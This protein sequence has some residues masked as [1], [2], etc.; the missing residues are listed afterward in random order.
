[1]TI[2][3]V[4]SKQWYDNVNNTSLPECPEVFDLEISASTAESTYKNTF[5]LSR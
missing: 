1:M 5:V 3:N 2:F 4:S